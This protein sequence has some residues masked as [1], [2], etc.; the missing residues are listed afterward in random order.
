M[1]LK[2]PAPSYQKKFYSIQEYLEME[3]DSLEKHEY[4][5]GEIFA[6]AGAGNLH[7]VI[8]KNT[9]GNLYLML[10]G[11]N[12]QPYGSDMRI[13]IPENSLFT[14]PDISIICGDIRNSGEDED[15]V[16]QPAIIIEILSPSTKSY[17]RG[18]KFMLYRAIRTL[19]EYILIDSESIHVEHFAINKEGL[20]QLKEHN[21]QE[22]KIIIET[23][24]VQ[25]PLQDV[26]EGSKL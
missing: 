8:F 20:W 12:C 9:Y 16:T 25:L 19:K 23:V 26:Y 4:Y 21:S 11:K 14:Y 13:H 6:M 24:N 1:E 7:N 5:K 15:T 17:D 18:Q 3:K 10:K 2:E 22:E